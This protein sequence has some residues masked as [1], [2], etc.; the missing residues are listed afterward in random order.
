MDVLRGSLTVLVAVLMG[1]VVALHHKTRPSDS[2]RDEIARGGMFAIAWL[3][4]LL[5]FTYL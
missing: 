2:Q 3:L 5:G 1:L 4:S